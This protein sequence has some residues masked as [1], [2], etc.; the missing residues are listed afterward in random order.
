MTIDGRFHYSKSL[1]LPADRLS[2]LAEILGRYCDRIRYE[3]V[4]VNNLNIAFQSKEELL[5]YDNYGKKRV[6]ELVISGYHGLS[7]V[8][9]FELLS[10]KE[11]FS[12]LGYWKTA[13]CS[14]SFSDMKDA[15]HF[16]SDVMSLLHKATPS[17][18]WVGK[19]SVWGIMWL[20]SLLSTTYNLFAGKSLE[21][22][23]SAGVFFLVLILVIAVMVLFAA[24]D[25]FLIGSLFPP[26]T[27]AWGEE[28]RRAQKYSNLRSNIFWCVIIAI[29]VGLVTTCLSNA[30][31]T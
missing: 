19:L 18:W 22:H 1:V 30:V 6:K 14:Y 8:F 17:Y 28:L 16:Q 24:V 23:G 3:A 20:S 21:Y 11:W 13:K 25:R 10:E 2:G 7:R 26:I 9:R 15:D 4:T 27:F 31:F 5:S 12:L 29:L